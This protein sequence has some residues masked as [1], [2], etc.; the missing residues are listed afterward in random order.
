MSVRCPTIET[1]TAVL[2]EHRAELEDLGLSRVA[3]FG[4]TARGEERP[5]SDIDVLVEFAVPVGM[6]HFLDVKEYL[7][8]LLGTSVDLVTSA[9]LKPQLRKAILGEAVYAL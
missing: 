2:R 9:A 4:S 5:G 7:E 1:V 3:V 6:F 8:Q